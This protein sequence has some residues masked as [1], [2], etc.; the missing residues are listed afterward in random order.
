MGFPARVSSRPSLLSYACGIVQPNTSPP[1]DIR[2]S[3]LTTSS[4]AKA[5]KQGVVDTLLES[6][7]ER[8]SIVGE[9][10]ISTTCVHALCH[11]IPAAGFR[12]TYC[13]NATLDR[14]DFR[15][16]AVLRGVRLVSSSV[17]QSSG[18]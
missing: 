15:V 5:S 12:F 2:A 13:H 11:R 18:T 9:P 16:R 3:A 10:R 8:A 6:L 1:P 14:R 7:D 17:L 4:I